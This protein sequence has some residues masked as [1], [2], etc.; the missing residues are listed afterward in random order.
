M[1]RDGQVGSN[2]RGRGRQGIRGGGMLERWFEG[3]L[4]PKKRQ[5]GMVGE[6][7]QRG[8]DR[9]SAGEPRP[10][11]HRLTPYGIKR[12]FCHQ[13][14]CARH[15]SW[16]RSQGKMTWRR[17]CSSYCSMLVLQIWRSGESLTKSP[18]PPLSFKDT[19]NLSH[20]F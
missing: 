16:R 11:Q 8:V 20:P 15:K 14:D 9:P 17:H 10:S 4:T 7:K 19:R 3:H 12:H 18:N 5:T 1:R 13:N 6:T 2:G